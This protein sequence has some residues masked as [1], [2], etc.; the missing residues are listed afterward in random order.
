[1]ILLDVLKMLTI[2][3]VPLRT[4][5]DCLGKTSIECI[6]ETVYAVTLCFEV[7]E[8]TW[9]ETYPENPILVPWYECEVT[10]ILPSDEPNTLKIFGYVNFSVFT[11]YR[12]IILTDKEQ[13]D[14]R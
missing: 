14:V 11:E 13:T 5:I 12:K 3:S 8:E 6:P 4:K 2:D 1:M 7:E 10:A 9:V